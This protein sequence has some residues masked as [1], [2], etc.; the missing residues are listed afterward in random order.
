MA[1]RRPAGAPPPVPPRI[2]APPGRYRNSHNPISCQLV[3]GLEPRRNTGSRSVMLQEA[4]QDQGAD[5]GVVGR[6]AAWYR[7]CEA[8]RQV[9]SRT[10]PMPGARLVG[11]QAPGSSAEGYAD[12]LAEEHPRDPVEGPWCL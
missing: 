4:L 2:S 3:S 1:L 6:Q 11:R 10:S 5:Q 8:A 7:V 9:V 12:G